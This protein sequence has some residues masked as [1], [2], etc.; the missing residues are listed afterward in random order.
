MGSS[1]LV[2]IVGDGFTLVA[3]DT[4][5]ARSVIMMKK[6]LDKMVKLSSSTIMLLGGEGACSRMWWPSRT[7]PVP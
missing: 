3:A 5:Q 4:Q 2:G 1:F 6:D 7:S